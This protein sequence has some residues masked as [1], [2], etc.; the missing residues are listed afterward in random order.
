MRPELL[1]RE[2]KARFTVADLLDSFVSEVVSG[3]GFSSDDANRF[4]IAAASVLGI[5]V[6]TTPDFNLAGPGR[7]SDLQVDQLDRALFNQGYLKDVQM[8]TLTANIRIT[9]PE[10]ARCCQCEP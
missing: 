5:P 7:L 2:W 3:A 9:G 10:L 1:E 6:E 4:Y 8:R